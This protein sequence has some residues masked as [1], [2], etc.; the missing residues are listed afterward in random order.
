LKLNKKKGVYV[1]DIKKIS[2]GSPFPF[3]SGYGFSTGYELRCGWCGKVHN[4][5]VDDENDVEGDSVC[6]IHFGNIEVAECCFRDLE[7]AVYA[8]LPEIQA[9]LRFLV[10]QK[11]EEVIRLNNMANEI[12]ELAKKL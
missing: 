5:G 1:L 2:P 12:Q 3:K 11:T 7:K 4:E 9:W 8:W 10:G 6:S